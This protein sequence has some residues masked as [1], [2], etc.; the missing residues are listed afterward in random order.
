MSQPV[1]PGAP[2]YL[3]PLDGSH[4]AE[5]VLPAVEQLARH[6]QPR[7]LLL[8]IMEQHPPA[9]IHGERHLADIAEAKEYLGAIAARLRSSGAAV[10]TH[11]HGPGTGDV[12]RS[13]FEHAQELDANLVILCTHGS[14][15]LRGILFGSIAQQVLQHGTRSV[16]L[17]PPAEAER[18]PAFDLR[19]VLVP[20]DGT[21]AH[22]PALPAA[23]AM[24]RAFG[25]ELHLLLVIPTLGTLSDER[26]VPGLL[27]PQTMRAILDLAEQGAVDYLE[28]V[29]AQY[30]AE[31]LTVTAE[32]LRGDAVAAVLDLAERFDADLIVMASHGRTGLDALLAGSVAPRVAGRAF[33]P[34]LLVR[35]GEAALDEHG[36]EI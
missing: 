7:V 21:A 32:V 17:I 28:Q 34:L 30:R 16:L 26:A 25:A 11:V 12:A 31:G 18:Q 10:E 6:F 33:R 1:T 24:A 2:A 23:S 15:G 9:T 22:E 8:H 29:L 27:M 35:A 13:I 36:A 3:V 5:S 14:S 19:R 20:L 4:L